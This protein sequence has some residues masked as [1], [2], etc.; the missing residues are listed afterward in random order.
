MK[1]WKLSAAKA[2]FCELLDDVVTTRTPQVIVR[3]G[4]PQGVV[5]AYEDFIQLQE[6]KNVSQHILQ[7]AKHVSQQ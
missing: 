5:V 1:K 2:S 6:L 4:R 3:W 7:V